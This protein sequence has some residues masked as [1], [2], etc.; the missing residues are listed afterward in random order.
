MT[1]AEQKTAEELAEQAT[2]D[3]RGMLSLNLIAIRHELGV[4]EF[5]NEKWPDADPEQAGM[6]AEKLVKR[7]H[8]IHAIVQELLKRQ[9]FGD[10][11]PGPISGDEVA[12][13]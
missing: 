7:G 12:A 6:D 3:L 8:R 11:A 1:R 4:M 2:D 13:G 5:F 9:R 10:A